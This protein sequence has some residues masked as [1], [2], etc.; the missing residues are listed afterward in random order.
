[1]RRH[2]PYIVGVL[3]V[4]AVP[5]V[6]NN[7]SRRLLKPPLWVDPDDRNIEEPKERDVSELYDRMRNM[8]LRHIDLGYTA[9][10]MSNRPA[11]NVNAWDEVPDSTWFTNRI[12]RKAITPRE[13]LEGPPGLAP[14]GGKW[15]AEKLKTAGYTPGLRI[16]DT[17]GQRFVLK[18]DL[19][20]GPER[21]SAA[22][23]IGSLLMYAAGYNAPHNSIVTFRA[24]DLTVNEE[25]VYED[26]VGRERPMSSKD[27]VEQL[28]RVHRRPDGS[29]RGMASHFIPGK[30]LGAFPYW[31][32]RKDDPNDLV[33]HELRRE[34]RGLRV[35][36][37]WY[38]HVDV[39]EVN[40]YDTYVTVEDRSFVKHY[41][42]DFGST[43]G[44]G[45][46]VNGPCRVGYE[47]MFDGSAMG[48]TL[49]TLGK[50]E[51]PWEA[52]C[53]IPYPEVGW[54]EA[55]LFNADKWKANYPNLAFV[56]MDMSDGY[57]GAKIVT[58]FTDELIRALAEA[59]EYAR[60]E[61]TRYVEETFRRRRNKI[62]AYWLDVVT[63]LEAFELETGT[64]RWTL[65][66]EDIALERGYAAQ[67][68]RQYTYEV[69]DALSMARLERGQTQDL[70][71]I[72]FEAVADIQPAPTDRW[73]RTPLAVVEIQSNRRAEGTALP[74]RVVIGFEE[75]NPNPHVLGWEHAP[76]N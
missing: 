35:I 69:K 9:R 67:E 18:F 31:G 41:F 75:G 53:R 2:A 28:S 61:V 48:K 23:R 55:D 30:P 15:V 16:H 27:L 57:W 5:A 6:A 72:Q 71:G 63:P 45:D 56:E 76:K 1:M 52:L 7:D 65:R 17:S 24:E 47:Y 66:F 73:G 42:M 29:F 3:L 60:P 34:L 22:D 43:V 12:G 70:G 10:R 68:K 40:T 36:A 74:V 44:S 20:T 32:T 13:L 54:F 33:P 46:F 64:A 58:A 21:N 59:G 25:S 38:N 62:G 26:P 19:P 39:K 4:A 51:R 50:W 37:S 11:L 14:V 8:W 49:V